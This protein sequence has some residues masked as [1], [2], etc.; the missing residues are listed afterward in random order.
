M[1]GFPKR[2]RY[3]H[4]Y[5][6]SGLLISRVPIHHSAVTE[7]PDE[8]EPE[9]SAEVEVLPLTSNTDPSPISA[10]TEQGASSSYVFGSAAAPP[11]GPDEGAPDMLSKARL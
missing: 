7:H 2:Q 5:D 6:S 4:V 1:P 3:E 10:Q 9:D 8:A 11:K